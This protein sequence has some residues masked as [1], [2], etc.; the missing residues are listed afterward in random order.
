MPAFAYQDSPYAIRA[1][2]SEAHRYAWQQIAAP[3]TWLTGHVR[4]AIAAEMR[5]ARQCQFCALRKTALSPLAPL[6]GEHTRVTDLPAS[7]I[8]VV[9]RLSTDPARLTQ[10]WLAQVV[11]DDFTYGHYVELLSVVVATLSIDSMHQAL[12]LAL[13]A[14]PEP[15][16]GS[17]TEHVPHNLEHETAWVPMI[18]TPAPPDDDLWQG[19]TANVLRAMSLVPD[20]V[21]LLKV[22]SS[23]HYLEMA[24]VANP[25]ASGGRAISRAQIEL[26]AGRVSAIND[27]FY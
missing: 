22:L 9:H 25:A 26:L 4:V 3:G 7:I 24:D 15:Q 1:D 10:T 18:S 16:S 11:D 14:L 23:A 20:A 5:A 21:R 27:C 19:G 8:D 2:V 13:E 12:G 6:A 17:P